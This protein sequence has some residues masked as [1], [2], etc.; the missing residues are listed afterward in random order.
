MAGVKIS[1]LPVAPN[2]TLSDLLPTVQSGV[3]V[4]VTDSQILA[5]FNANASITQS[6]VIGLGATLAGYLS[7]SGGTMTGNL[8]LNADPTLP[9]Q[10]VTKQYADSIAAGIIIQPAAYAASTVNLNATFGNM[11]GVGDT[12]TNAGTQAVFT[13]DGVTPPVNS[14]ILVKNQTTTYQNGCYDLTNV[15]SVSTNWV[16]TRSTDYDTAAEI[17]PGT[18]FVI[19]NGTA[20]EATLWLQTQTV[21]TV[22]TDPILFSQFSPTMGLFLT[23][24]NNLSDV[25]NKITSI[26]NITTTG[27]PSAAISSTT[28]LTASNFGQEV[29]CTGASAYAVTLPTVSGNPERYIDFSIRTTSNALVTITPATGTIMGQATFVLGSNEGCRVVTD[30]NNWFVTNLT[31]QPVNASVY[32]NTNQT[33][34][35]AVFT[36]VLLDTV[37]YDIGSFFNIGTSRYQPLYSGKYTIKANVDY[38]IGAAA[39]TAFINMI[40]KNGVRLKQSNT[41]SSIGGGIGIP[42]SGDTFLNGSTDYIEVFTIQTSGSG[43]VLAIASTT[44]FLDIMRVSNF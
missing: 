26:Y 18:L 33:I 7:L 19:D 16:L 23:I 30:G 17:L 25:N 15:G 24:A 5:L 31:L 11:G 13:I 36:K 21:T 9:L 32:L 44:N 10:A 34:A 40:Y 14:R 38:S 2:A 20:N 1:Q 28:T 3:T 43:G 6:Q 12:L 39:N 4:K 22:D 35:T 41:T 42:I 8:I 27:Y 29:I 37:T